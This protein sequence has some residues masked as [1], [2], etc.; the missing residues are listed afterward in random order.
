MQSDMLA[1]ERRNYGWLWLVAIAVLAAVAI[2][3]WTGGLTSFRAAASDS[4]QAVFLTNDQVY[5]GKLSRPNSDYPIL[6]D[7]YYLQVTQPLQ[8]KEPGAAS[9]PNISLVKLGGELHG[10][11]D[12]M[13]LNKEHI[14]F[15]EDLKAD[16]Q[17]VA[18]ILKDKESK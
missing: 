1:S 12:E 6:R 13:F 11:Q 8:P 3:W 10:P 15:Y 17:V 7:V 2:L 18:A 14:L 5:F 16:S 4:Y 9:T